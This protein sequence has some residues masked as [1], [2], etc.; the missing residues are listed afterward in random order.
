MHGVPERIE[1]LRLAAYDRQ[2]RA[3]GGGDRT[4]AVTRRRTLAF[5][6]RRRQARR[7]TGLRP[8]WWT[9]PF[10]AG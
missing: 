1:R 3:N 9:T 2:F 4:R 5:L 10:E 6:R 7:V 8:F